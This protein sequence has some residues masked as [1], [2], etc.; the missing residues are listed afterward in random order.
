MTYISLR[1]YEV[2]FQHN[3][4]NCSTWTLS[5]YLAIIKH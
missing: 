5:E 1:R 3:I 4:Y 2:F